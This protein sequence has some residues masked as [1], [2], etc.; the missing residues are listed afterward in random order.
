MEINFIRIYKKESVE[1]LENNRNARVKVF[2]KPVY[3]CSK[4]DLINAPIVGIL[5]ER[6]KE[7]QT[8]AYS[9]SSHRFKFQLS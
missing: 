7:S 5:Y 9:R 3:D 4:L 1:I 6:K 2:P 8:I